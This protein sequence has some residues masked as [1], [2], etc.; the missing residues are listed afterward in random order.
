MV[1]DTRFIRGR[2][3]VAGVVGPAWVGGW[4]FTIGY[5]H[6]HVLK[7]ILALVVWPYFLGAAMGR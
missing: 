6:L 5:L 4:L 1:D 2:M 3:D 7:A